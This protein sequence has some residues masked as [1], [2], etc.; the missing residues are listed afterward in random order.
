MFLS[1]KTSLVA[2]DI[3]S[4]SIKL[5]QLNPLKNN[6]Y[7]LL[8]FGV[9]PL[10]HESIVDGMVKN[11]DNVV[12]ALIRLLKAENVKTK[13]A[14]AS[15]SGETVIIKKIRLPV[16]SYE[17][18]GGKIK[19]EA[20]QYIP[21]DIE[22]VS[23]DYQ[24][25]KA[26]Q[27]AMEK[28]T[29]EDKELMEVLLVAVQRETIDSR[30]EIL[31]EAGLKP[32]I[33]DLDVFAMMNATR[34]STNLERVSGIA[35][36]DLGSSFTHINILSQGNTHFTRDFRVGGIQCTEKLMASLGVSYEEA[37][38]CKKGDIPKKVNK[39]AVIKVIVESFNPILEEIQN[40]LDGFEN[41]TGKPVERVLLSGGGALING[42]AD[43]FGD[44]LGLPVEIQDPLK[45]L[46][47][48]RKKFD[49]DCI[50][51]MAP[52]ATV[53]LGLAARKFD[54]K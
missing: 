7:E 5:A 28:K 13:F 31:N 34:L 40:A 29:P 3:G 45:S 50:A 41:A 53:V 43:L 27:Q 38:A 20:E 12:D 33:I 35:L 47:I 19:A 54:Y 21:F 17:E 22:D 48:N 39:D 46:K 26:P 51:E 14:V 6:S 1:G 36:I 42:V 52:I 10:P 2:V 4:Y 11:M 25:I 9:M 23:M 37:N 18:L 49:L 8:S 44:R 24:I 30:L 16:M 15:V 32:V